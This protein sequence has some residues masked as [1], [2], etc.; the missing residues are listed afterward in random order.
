MKLPRIHDLQGKVVVLTGGA[1]VLGTT[2]ARALAM[3]NAK[4]AILDLN[5]DAAQRIADELVSEGYTAIAVECNVLKK[6]SIEQA[7]DIVL[8]SFKGIDIL[9]NGAGGNHPK[10]T[11]G[12]EFFE[13]GDLEK[14]IHTFN[15]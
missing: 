6:E 10:G 1:G 15:N 4:V 2:F 9:I 8:D 14:D 13:T 3:A 12:H 11:T 5:L 7:K